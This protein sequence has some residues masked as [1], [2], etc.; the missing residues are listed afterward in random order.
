MN[1]KR[2]QLVSVYINEGDEWRHRPLHLQIL[3][4]LYR[5]GLSGGTV[6]RGVAG[7]TGAQGVHSNSLVD[8]GGKLPL[9]VQFIDTEEE[10][11]RILPVLREMTPHRLVTVQPVDVIPPGD[12]SAPDR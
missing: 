9:I 1:G 10:V 2:F 6:V 8:A 7:F 5:E 11:K 3:E 4:M 12:P